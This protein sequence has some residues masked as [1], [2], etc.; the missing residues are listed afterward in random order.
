MSCE[1]CCGI[2]KLLGLVDVK[3]ALGLKKQAYPIDDWAAQYEEDAVDPEI[4]VLDA[5]H[6]FFDWLNHDKGLPMPWWVRKLIFMQDLGQ[7]SAS[8]N[9]VTLNSSYCWKHTKKGHSSRLELVQSAL[10]QD[11]RAMIQRIREMDPKLPY[12][13]GSSLPHFSPYTGEDLLKDIRGNGKGHKAGRA[14]LPSPRLRYC[15]PK[16]CTVAFALLATKPAPYSHRKRNTFTP[17]VS[18]D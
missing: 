18:T 6:H 11:G 14:A 17:A 15:H 12:S 2:L 16:S 9:E 7:V 10:I 13:F 1:C 4:A 5:H 8:S 3:L